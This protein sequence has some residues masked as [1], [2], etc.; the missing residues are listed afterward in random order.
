MEA[1]VGFPA[2]PGNRV[3]KRG[4]RLSVHQGYSS[5]LMFRWLS[6][7][8]GGAPCSR[9]QE[10]LCCLLAWHLQESL[11][12]LLGHDILLGQHSSTGLGLSCWCWTKCCS[13]N[14]HEQLCQGLHLERLSSEKQWGRE[15]CCS[16]VL[17]LSPAFPSTFLPRLAGD[18][19]C[20]TSC[21]FALCSFLETAGQGGHRHDEE[22]CPASDDWS[23]QLYGDPV[24]WS[25]PHICLKALCM[26]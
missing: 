7:L 13:S 23:F 3:H 22:W 9:G 6:S 5:L 18:Q 20:E 15:L 10:Q 8:W 16:S 14:F 17:L 25:G 2:Q 11:M 12:I 1:G 24:K 21:G 4:R 19:P 26:T